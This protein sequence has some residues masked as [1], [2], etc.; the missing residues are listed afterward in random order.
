MF[1]KCKEYLQKHGVDGISIKRTFYS[2]VVVYYNNNPIFRF[3]SEVFFAFYSE[4]DLA[5]TIMEIL[6]ENGD[7]P[8]GWENVRC[9]SR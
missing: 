6:Y 9:E 8:Q 2:N 3:D 4:R 7:I 1:S 5:Y